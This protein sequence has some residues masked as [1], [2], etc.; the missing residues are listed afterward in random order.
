MLTIYGLHATTE[1]R[2]RNNKLARSE[3]R[4]VM[5]TA[6][7]DAAWKNKQKPQDHLASSYHLLNYSVRLTIFTQGFPS[8]SSA[9][10]QHIT[11]FQA[12][13]VTCKRSILQLFHVGHSMSSQHKKILTSSDFDET[14]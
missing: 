12:G 4:A 3:R 8:S 11:A 2:I 10:S 6:S 9:W 7:P 1:Y 14:W 13:D 5:P